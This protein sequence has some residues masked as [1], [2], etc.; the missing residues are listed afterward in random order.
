MK[1]IERGIL[2]LTTIMTIIVGTATIANCKC[3]LSTHESEIEPATDIS[4]MNKQVSST[5]A[6]EVKKQ[7]EVG[8][9][10]EF[11]SYPYDKEGTEKP[12]EWQILEKY[13]DGTALILT[14]NVIDNISY[15]DR[16]EETSWETSS[17]RK[18]LNEYFY[19]KAFSENE[20]KLIKETYLHEEGTKDNIFM[21]SRE[22]AEKYFAATPEKTLF[23]A[24]IKQDY[25]YYSKNQSRAAYP[26][27]YAKNKENKGKKLFTNNYTGGTCWWWLRSFNKDSRA[28][29]SCIYYGGEMSF[30]IADSN[31]TGVRP[32]L[33]ISVK[34]IKTEKD[35][36]QKN[37]RS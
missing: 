30:C 20:K 4:C 27:P 36:K 12:I 31:S 23:L 1:T 37:T 35:L 33:I 21:L 7:Y 25:P 11:G 2:L 19:S 10:I 32:A 28:S 16:L 34:N 9:I 13:E 29:F 15:N 14:R 26:T 17:I 6:T 18:W 5:Q 3:W 24:P 22:E 8:D